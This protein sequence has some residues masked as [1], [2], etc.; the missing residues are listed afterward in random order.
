MEPI[1]DRSACGNIDTR[2]QPIEPGDAQYGLAGFDR[3]AGV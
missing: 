3:F 1:R 2:Q